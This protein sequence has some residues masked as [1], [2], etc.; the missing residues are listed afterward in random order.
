MKKK[1]QLVQR[2]IHIY[3]GI[4]II[5]TLYYQS[6]AVVLSSVGLVFTCGIWI[7]SSFA[8]AQYSNGMEFSMLVLLLALVLMSSATVS[9]CC[10]TCASAR[11]NSSNLKQ[12]LE[13]NSSFK[14]RRDVQ[15]LLPLRVYVGLFFYVSKSTIL[16]VLS[17]NVSILITL[18]LGF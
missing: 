13:Y 2:R 11:A 16:T 8:L 7:F 18:L 17:N 6:C 4:Q 1:S 14:M 12:Y 9:T 5:N 15:Q 3:K 10:K